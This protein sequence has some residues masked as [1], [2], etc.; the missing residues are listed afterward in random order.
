LSP[1]ILD[2]SAGVEIAMRSLSGRRLLNVLVGAGSPAVAPEH[3]LVEAAGVL[4]RLEGNG[5]ITGERAHTALSR[6]STLVDTAEVGPLLEEA[7]GLRANLTIAD[8]VYVVLARRMNAPL[9]TLD[10]RLAG[11]P[12]LGIRILG[13]I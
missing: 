1:V 12:N 9:V 4:R 2:A 10:G 5:S 11:A 8:A 13:P 7:W 3:F 6:L